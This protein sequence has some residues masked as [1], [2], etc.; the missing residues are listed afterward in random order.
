[1]LDPTELPQVLADTIK[2]SAKF[3]T[4]I[5][6]LAEK[7]RQVCGVADFDLC[8]PVCITSRQED[9][10]KQLKKATSKPQAASIITELLN[11]H[12]QI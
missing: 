10:L 2:I 6:N 4:G 8:K 3:G 1:V 5:D 9:L 11:G 12:L 7:I